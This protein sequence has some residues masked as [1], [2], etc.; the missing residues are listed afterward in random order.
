MRVLF[1]SQLAIKYPQVKNDKD[2]SVYFGTFYSNNEYIN[3]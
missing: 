1:T 2:W 3:R